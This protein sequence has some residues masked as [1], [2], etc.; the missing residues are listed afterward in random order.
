MNKQAK[1]KEV[2]ISLSFRRS[3]QSNRLFE[4]ADTDDEQ[5]RRPSLVNEL[6]EIGMVL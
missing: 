5:R 3:S 2:S 6:N 4:S 1:D